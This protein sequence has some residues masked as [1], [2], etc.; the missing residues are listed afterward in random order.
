MRVEIGGISY[1][2]APFNGYYMGTEI[3][4]NLG[5]A[6]RY[7]ML[8]VIAARMGLDTTMNR[9]LWK[10]A[11]LVVLNQA[12][13]FSFHKQGITIVDHH[14]ASNQFVCHQ[15]REEQAGRTTYGD[16]GWLVPPVSGSLSP[17]FHRPYEDRVMKPNI[18]YQSTPFGKGMTTIQVEDGWIVQEKEYNNIVCEVIV[19]LQEQLTPL[20]WEYLPPDAKDALIQHDMEKGGYRWQ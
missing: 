15:R 11:A 17:L 14:T 19:A 20:V 9:S 18:F 5:D 12:I 1:T 4:R 8:P 3:G 10:D 7:N 13:L 2:A 16:W 6:N